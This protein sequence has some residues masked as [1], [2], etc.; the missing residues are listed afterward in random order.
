MRQWLTSYRWLL[1]GVAALTALLVFAACGDD[2]DDGAAEPTA[3]VAA[4]ETPSAEAPC[5]GGPGVR[6]IAGG[7]AH[8]QA[9]EAL[10]I[11]LLVPF[12]GALSTFGPDYENAA[13]L[14]V[15]CINNAGGV[16]G[17]PVELVVGDTATN[18][19]QGVTEAERLV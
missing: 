17:G 4:G 18:P 15:K 5:Q 19:E 13:K 12:T 2:D 14:A 1:I 7:G 8:A 6:S 10:K 3:T 9:A 11:G 16:N